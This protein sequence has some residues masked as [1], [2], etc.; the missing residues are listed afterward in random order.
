LRIDLLAAAMAPNELIQG[1][2]GRRTIYRLDDR[3]LS[4]VKETWPVISGHLETVIDNFLVCS[5]G[6]PLMADAITH[7]FSAL[8]ALEMSHFKSLLSGE[9][10]SDYVELC[11]KTVKEEAA[12]GLDARIRS[13]AGNHVLTGAI[14]AISLK[15]CFS[16]AKMAERCCAVSQVIGFDI[17]NAMT[18]HMEAAESAMQARRHIIDR[19]I[20]DFSGATEE[21]VTAVH[22]AAASLSKTCSKM[23]EI[24][25]EIRE[26]M[27]SASLA[28]EEIKNKM[29]A[30]AAATDGLSAQID[31]IS[32]KTTGGLH[33][34]QA[35][36]ERTK[37]TNNTVHSLEQAAGRI[38]SIIELISTIASQT[39]LLA[40]NATI[41]AARAGQAGKGFAVVASEVKALAGQTSHAAEDVGKQIA[42]IQGAIEL[43]VD[44]ISSIAQT[45]DDL[46]AVSTSI[47]AAVEEQTT[48]T[49]EIAGSIQ[50]AARNTA[51]AS[52]EIC[53]IEEFAHRSATHVGEISECGERLSSCTREL[54]MKVGAFLSS[55][56][57]A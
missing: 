51:Q 35:A 43:S 50:V 15:Y 32:R 14:K 55:V 10:G 7:N 26:S 13:S 23:K 22:A 38:G 25:D 16:S 40:L 8:K 45:I 9:L 56:R 18:L 39:N 44:E 11:R 12:M 48:T 31:E 49:R 28:S 33:L 37:N 21:V 19:A 24:T 34:T 54:Q 17:A 29:K 42:A 2:Q 1:Y 30:T 5:K 3:A 4:V 47:A 53:S 6:I 36:V 20:A 57:A 41:E 46:K 52:R 27:R